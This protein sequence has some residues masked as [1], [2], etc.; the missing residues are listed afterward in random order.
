MIS[1]KRSDHMPTWMRHATAKSRPGADAPLLHPERLDGD[2]VAEDDAPVDRGVGPVGR[3]TSWSYISYGSL[4][5]HAMNGSTMYVYVTTH[6]VTRSILAMLSRWFF[7]MTSFRPKISRAGI[8]SWS[9]IAKPGVDGA[10]DEVRRED[11]RVPAGQ[12]RD[13]EVE[14]DV[15]VDREDERRREA[16]EDE[17]RDAVVPPVGELA[18]PP[19]G[20][21]CRRCAVEGASARGRAPPPGRG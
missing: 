1:M 15:G 10:G 8:I 20:D 13:R 2:A 3:S 11:R 6:P 5:H 7:V 4:L 18:A 12:L 21:R 17:V 14:A 9:T 19:E 16:A